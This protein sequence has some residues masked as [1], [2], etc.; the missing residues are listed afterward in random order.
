MKTKIISFCLLVFLITAPTKAQTWEFVGLDSMVIKHLYVSGDTIY[1]G[2]AIRNGANINSGLYYTFDR[3]N[4]WIQLDSALGSGTIVGM[5]YLGE[6]KIFLIKGLS[7]ASLAGNLYKTTNNGLTWEPIN[8]SSYGVRWIEV[9]PFNQNKIYAIDRN[10]F[11]AGITNTLFKSTNQGNSWEDISAFPSSSHGSEISFAFDLPDSLSLFVTVDTQFN[12]YLYKSTNEGIDWFYVSEPPIVPSEIYT[13]YFLSNRIY[14][15]PMEYLSIDG[16]INW[17]IADSGLTLNSDFLSFYQDIF[18]TR[19]LYH[20]RTDG[21]YFSE[22]D[23]T[24]WERIVGSEKLPLV[25]GTGGFQQGRR[26]MKNV[27]IDRTANKIYVGTSSGIFN[28]DIITGSANEIG[29][30]LNDFYLYQN[31][32]NPFN[33]ATTIS[34]TLPERSFITIKVYDILGKERKTLIEENQTA[35]QYELKFFADELQSG[36]YFYVLTANSESGVQTKIVK[37]MILIK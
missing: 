7:E 4:N 22:R 17:V 35:G 32:P 9:S 36:V 26:N 10:S 13:D 27:V 25:L 2:T 33:P 19:L 5:I 12:K 21:L 20:L 28:R 34:Y 15:F 23:T 30:E 6:G 29:S 18:T 1:A 3:G 8:I 31:Y 11:P 24:Y 16:G 37:K 14:L